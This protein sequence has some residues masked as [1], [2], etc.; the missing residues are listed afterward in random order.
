MSNIKLICPKCNATEFK[1]A[2]VQEAVVSYLMDDGGNVSEQLESIDEATKEFKLATCAHCNAKVTT[3][4]L[5][6]GMQSDISGKWYPMDQLC[7]TEMEDEDGTVRTVIL[8]QE[9]YEKMQAPSVDEMSEEQLREHAKS[10]DE[11][12]SSLQQQMAEMMAKMEQLLS[13][14]VEPKQEKAKKAPK[15]KPVVE[16]NIKTP[17]E[18]APQEASEEE[19]VYA[20]SEDGDSFSFQDGDEDSDLGELETIPGFEAPF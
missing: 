1:G 16:T 2:L 19:P 20:D 9:E 14:A 6:Q 5:V 12:I 8:T 18:E 4:T 3:K 11:T 13:G 15:E 17:D 7:Q 10:Q